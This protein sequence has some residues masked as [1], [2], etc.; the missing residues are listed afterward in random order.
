MAS[1][2]NRRIVANYDEVARVSPLDILL[3]GRYSSSA[4]GYASRLG[5]F[6]ADEMELKPTDRVL[7]AGCS[8]GIYHPELAAR[9]GTLVGIDAS[10]RS[11][12]RAQARHK[13]LSNVEYRIVEL[14]DLKASDF[15]RPFDKILCY[16][17]VHF[18]G[19]MAE[20]EALMRAFIGLL[21]GGHGMIFLGEVR[22]REMYERFQQEQNKSY[23]RNVKFSLLKK[24]QKWLLRSGTYVAADAPTL[25]SRQEI[26]DLVARL[27][28]KC[29]RIEQASWHPFYNTCADYRLRF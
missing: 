22:E 15:P 5:R 2:K 7:D 13:D 21:D 20:F 28:G 19:D 27:G 26:A 14:T 4:F 12:E 9:A 17:V 11:I 6:L 24:I 1:D 18:L 23:L 16:S 3:T 8:V 10:P 29:E 25:F